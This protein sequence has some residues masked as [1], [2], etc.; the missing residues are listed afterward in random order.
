MGLGQ[1]KGQAGVLGVA[2]TSREVWC[3]QRTGDFCACGGSC[4][5][6]I[7]EGGFAPPP[8]TRGLWAGAQAGQLGQVSEKGW[9]SQAFVFRSKRFALIGARSVRQNRPE[10]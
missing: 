2:G 6:W 3:V 4:P 7:R 9:H 8:G 1:D 10:K 5:A